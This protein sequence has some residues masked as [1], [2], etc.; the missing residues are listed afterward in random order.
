MRRKPINHRFCPN[1][2]CPLRGQF[3]QGNV[4]RHGFQFGK[5]TLTPA[6]QAGLL[7]KRLTFREIFT[8]AAGALLCVVVLLVGEHSQAEDTSFSLA[9]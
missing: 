5:D 7:S 4:I 8:A 9:A 2:D 3:R 6:M 1:T